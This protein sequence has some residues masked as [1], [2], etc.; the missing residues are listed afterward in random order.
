MSSHILFAACRGARRVCAPALPLFLLSQALL[1]ATALAQQALPPVE[2]DESTRQSTVPPPQPRR[3]ADTVRRANRNAPTG[4]PAEQGG[5]VVTSPTTVPTPIA[6]VASSITVITAADIELKQRRLLADA[7]ADVPGLNIVQT[8]GPGGQTSVF[9]RGTN[10]NHTKVLVD[11]ID[12]SDPSN[13]N[14]TFDL[15]QMLTGDIARIEVL[16][17]PQSGLY[18]ADAI[19]GVISITTK[20]GE[21][22]PKVFARVEGGSFG[23]FNQST[24]VSGAQDRF[25]YAFSVQHWRS[26]STPVTPLEVLTPNEIRNNDLYDNKTLST[27]LGYDFSDAFSLN[28]VSRYTRSRLTFTSDF[29]D[30]AGPDILQTDQFDHQS[31]S[32]GEAV[33]S[34]F[35]G[36]FK[37]YFGLAYTNA[38]TE[39]VF[40]PDP[41]NGL[42]PGSGPLKHAHQARLARCRDGRRRP[43]HRDGPRGRDVRLQPVLP[44]R[45]HS[46]GV[47]REQG[48]LSRVAGRVRAAVL[49]RRQRAA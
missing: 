36:R 22:P 49:P 41:A 43:D 19:G 42:E 17:G 21:G 47:E 4:A 29:N 40:P 15:G 37:N 3:S 9:I 1:S 18:G 35:D 33:W 2:V 12:V 8:G 31:Y 46:H 7:L 28:V 6:E 44:V 38:Q 45:R 14:Q 32:R 13:P 27:R 23:T 26:T 5:D 30:N 20:K 48:R 10:S 25:N 34:L 16:R 11:G 24:G 39:N